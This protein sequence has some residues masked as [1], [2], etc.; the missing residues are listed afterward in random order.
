VVCRGKLPAFIA[1]GVTV[2]IGAKMPDG[3]WAHPGPFEARVEERS[4]EASSAGVAHLTLARAWNRSSTSPGEEGATSGLGIFAAN[5]DQ[6]SKL[7]GAAFHYSKLP[8]IKAESYFLLGRAA[9]VLQKLGQAEQYYHAAYKNCDSLTP[10]AFGRAQLHI[11][12]KEYT[13]AI[14]LLEDVVLKDFPDHV[15][16]L[17]I[18]GRLHYHTANTLKSQ[19]EFHKHRKAIKKALKYLNRAVEVEKQDHEIWLVRAQV[20]QGEPS[21]LPGARESY[22]HAVALM[23]SKGI[24]IHPA[25]LTNLG[26]LQ[27]Q[28]KLFPEARKSYFDALLE[29]EALRE[30]E[31]VPRQ[32]KKPRLLVSES[33]NQIF[34]QWQPIAGKV[35]GKAGDQA[36]EVSEDLRQTLPTKGGQIL[37]N[38]LR[39]ELSVEEDVTADSLPLKQPLLQD[40]DS[41]SVSSKVQ[42]MEV[43]SSNVTTCFNLAIL[44]ES[45]GEWFAATELYKAILARFP[46]HIDANLRLGHVH[47]H[48]GA[49]HKALQYYERGSKQN[50][51]NPLPLAMAGDLY[52][53]EY[54]EKPRSRRQRAKKRRAG[55]KLLREDTAP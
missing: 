53:E 41:V 26:A 37:A 27:C 6:V 52:L 14:K 21:K 32:N 18:L 40:L 51:K 20:L 34:W 48:L 35:S 55:Q 8:E 25:I 12:K 29:N 17:H 31:K 19:Q 43:G 1:K 36:L 15:D 30:A 44:H 45:S 28:L 9:H 39:L 38:G 47:R 10:A 3:G 7:A 4:E 33:G 2:R 5:L 54:S 24:P 13:K 11:N 42:I 23:K 16:A 49:S 22:E 46:N 50:P